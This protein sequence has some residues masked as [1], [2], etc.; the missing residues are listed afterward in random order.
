MTTTLAR[1]FVAIAVAATA[2][3]LSACDVANLGTSTPSTAP[4]PAARW[5]APQPAAVAGLQ[6]RA[7]P[8]L[9]AKPTRQHGTLVVDAAGMTLYRSDKDSASP[10]TSRCAGACAKLWK[11]VSPTVADLWA[12]GID[13]SIVGTVARAD[14]TRQLTLAGWPV[15]RFVKDARPGDVAGQCKGG[16]FAVT[17]QG[18]KSM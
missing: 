2:A 14:G 13:Q 9:R 7:E 16:F 10:P 12:A 4:A 17:P 11:P 15:Y 5:T 3:T 8:T 1:A 6:H 18:G